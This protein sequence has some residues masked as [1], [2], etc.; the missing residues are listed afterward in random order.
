MWMPGP[1][2][3]W[4]VLTLSEGVAMPYA[5]AALA[6][7]VRGGRS[8]HPLGWDLAA[9]AAA[10]VALGCKNTFLAL[11]PAQFLLRV[12]PDGEPLV[13][14]LRRRGARAALLL[15]SALMPVAH[16]AF[17]L[18]DWR[19]GQY[20]AGLP[21]TSRLR[22]MGVV[23]FGRAGL[24][25]LVPSLLIGAA[26][27]AAARGGVVAGLAAVWREQRAVCRAG[28]VLLAGGIAVY[29]P[30]HIP[31]GY[32]YAIPAVWGGTL[33][34]A[35]LLN[36]LWPLRSR[37]TAR[38]AIGLWLSALATFAVDNLLAQQH[39]IA[40]AAPLW[41]ALRIVER[42]AAPG[43]AVG[44]RTL[45]PEI[46]LGIHFFWHLRGRG[47]GDLDGRLFD[48]RDTPLRRPELSPPGDAPLA[49]LV[50]TVP[51]L[52]PGDGWRQVRVSS[53][54]YDF[55][56]RHVEAWIWQRAVGSAA[57]IEEPPRAA[58]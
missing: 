12:A 56:R 2:E 13:A 52:P 37:R 17:Y 27:V 7:A 44:V 48:E 26:A 50:S 30:V 54:A 47:R 49:W 22:D 46:G 4:R 43:A 40:N 1:N 51:G 55:G 20:A 34:A 31:A 28:V 33:L 45:S 21:T 58:D 35:A 15:A 3:V 16:F 11:I 6:C 25:C 38:V 57:V 18:H 14:A 5:F 53:A 42:E 39:V 9:I 32:R 8:R 36:S 29:L 23:V 24:G 19:P 10:L 41:Q